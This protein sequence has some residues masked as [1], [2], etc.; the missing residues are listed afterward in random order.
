MTEIKSNV[1]LAS[2]KAY[3]REIG[4]CFGRICEKISV[5][6]CN[7]Q[8]DFLRQTPQHFEI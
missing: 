8:G 6:A 4:F 7:Y 5:I 1:F 2:N 3:G